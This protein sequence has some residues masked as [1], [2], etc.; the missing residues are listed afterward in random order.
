MPM[1]ILEQ[2]VGQ[3][4][5]IDRC[6]SDYH[7]AIAKD[8]TVNLPYYNRRH[9]AM[10]TLGFND[11]RDHLRVRLHSRGASSTFSREV[12]VPRGVAGSPRSKMQALCLQIETNT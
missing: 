12:T 1:S 3:L 9:H 10:S 5:F 8:L 6:S 2:L 4:W 7:A 11:T